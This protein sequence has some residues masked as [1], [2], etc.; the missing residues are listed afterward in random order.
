MLDSEAVM[1]LDHGTEIF[2]WVGAAADVL[3]SR[4]AYVSAINFLK[5]NGKPLHTPIHLFNEGTPITSEIWNGVFKSGPS[6]RKPSAAPAAPAAPAAAAAPAPVAPAAAGAMSLADLQN[7]DVW[8]AKGVDAAHRET[9]L[10]DAE[11]EA[12]FG[13]NK[14]AFDALPKWKK[15]GEKKKHG[16]F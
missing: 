2:L 4:N 8:R 12:T 10:G 11:F 5:T 15:D 14:G 1:M 16:L 7:A 3:E 9:Y 13:M 6:V